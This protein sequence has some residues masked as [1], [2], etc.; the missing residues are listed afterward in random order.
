MIHVNPDWAEETR[1][2][3]KLVQRAQSGCLSWAAVAAVIV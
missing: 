3:L 2:H 1:L